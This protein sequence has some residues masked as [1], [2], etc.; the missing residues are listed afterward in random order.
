MSRQEIKNILLVYQRD[1]AEGNPEHGRVQ[2]VAK[3]CGVSPDLVRDLCKKM[4]H[5]VYDPNSKYYTCLVKLDDEKI[6]VDQINF[7]RIA[8]NDK[9][10]R[11]LRRGKDNSLP[12][13]L[14]PWTGFYVWEMS[15]V[16]REG[17]KLPV[18]LIREDGIY[19]FFGENDHLP[20]KLRRFRAEKIVLSILRKAGLV[21]PKNVE[22]GVE[23]ED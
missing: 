4:S 12:R 5:P 18:F 13:W 9:M 8:L 6:L 10:R 2:R 17:R 22:Q 21:G 14:T 23:S 15:G 3:K 7:S 16:D 20:L 19:E 1:E 11:N